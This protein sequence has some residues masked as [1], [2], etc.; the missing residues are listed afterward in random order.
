VAEDAPHVVVARD[1]VALPFHHRDVRDGIRV[2]QLGKER[3]GIRELEHE[4]RIERGGDVVHGGAGSAG[5][6]RR[7]C[8]GTGECEATRLT[9]FGESCYASALWWFPR[10]RSASLP[11]RTSPPCAPGRS[12]TRQGLARTSGASCLRRAGRPTSGS[13]R[14]ATRT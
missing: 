6:S 3:I 5:S 14:A 4:L 7:R 12:S 11:I 10:C 9:P 2:A 13:S 8:T 1:D